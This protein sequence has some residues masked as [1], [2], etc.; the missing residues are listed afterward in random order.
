MESKTRTGVRAL[1][2]G[3]LVTAMITAPTPASAQ[4]LAHPQDDYA[5]SQIARHEGTGGTPLLDV[6]A[7]DDAL[8][9]DVSSHQGDVDWATV[10][11]NGGKFSYAKATEGITYTNPNF[12]QQYNG[13]YAAGLAHGAYHFALPDVSD[14]AT[15]ANYFVDHGGGWSK[16]GRTLPPALDIEYNP[17]GDTCYKLTPEQMTAW[18]KAFSDQMWRRT[19]IPPTIYTSYTWW[20]K[21][22]G[23]TTLL[24][25]NPLWIPRYGTDVGTLPGGWTTQAIWQFADKGVF[26]G[27]QNRF[28]GNADRLHAF[29]LG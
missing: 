16:D 19:G 8:G 15:Q 3:V 2:A 26:P 14:G 25:G 10:A 4:P 27:D 24:R 13:S 20:T 6:K 18:I 5:G 12:A 9:L 29:T 11:R 23:N 17:Y 1:L 7:D 22:T 28:N 21:C